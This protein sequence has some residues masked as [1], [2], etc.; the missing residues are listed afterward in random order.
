M[1]VDFQTLDEQTVTLR[2]LLTMKQ[3]RVPIKDIEKV[4]VNLSNDFE[5]WEEVCKQY[6]AFASQ[7]KED[8]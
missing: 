3:L 2:E 7:E 1:T 8:D 4:L 6:P 5:T